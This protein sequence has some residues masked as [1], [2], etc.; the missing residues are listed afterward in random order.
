M[1]AP[2]SDAIMSRLSLGDEHFGGTFQRVREADGSQRFRYVVGQPHCSVV[3][4]RGLEKVRR[5]RGGEFT[6]SREHFL[7]AERLRQRRARAI[8]PAKRLLIHRLEA[9]AVDGKPGEWPAERADGFALACDSA[10]LYVLFEGKDDRAVFQNTATPDNFLEAFKTGDVVDVMLETRAG[11]DPNR[12]N[13]A[14]GDI[15]LSFAMVGGEPAAI[16]YDHVVPGTPQ[17]AR[18]PFASPWR[19]LYIDR[20]SLIPEAR[21]AVLRK[22]N[23]Y[24]LE[25][26]VPLEAIHFD[27]ADRQAVRGDLGR[28]LSDQ[29]GTRAVDRVYWS[30][31]NTKIVSDVPSEAR[32]QPNL[33]GTFVLQPAKRR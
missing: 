33:W 29:T 25:A 27:P 9:I 7:D 20:V 28:V 21:I 2:P 10:H 23:R 26:A 16:L 11:L 6:V 31:K 1:D 13:A 4:L 17:E 3:E 32:L 18:L 5:L 22:G 14:E 30:N 24:S 12:E 15:R 8:A 19:T